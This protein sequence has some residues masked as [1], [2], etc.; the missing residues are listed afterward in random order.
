[1]PICMFWP[2]DGYNKNQIKNVAYEFMCER[3]CLYRHRRM[4]DTKRNE[5]ARSAN[6]SII[7]LTPFNSLPLFVS[8]SANK[9]IPDYDDGEDNNNIEMRRK[10]EGTNERKKNPR[11][12]LCRI[13]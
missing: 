3:T 4:A 2:E 11:K 8:A 9:F 12:K 7:Y 10:R 6:K 13:H 5:R 1:M